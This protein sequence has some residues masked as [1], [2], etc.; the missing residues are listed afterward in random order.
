MKYVKFL[1][2]PL[3]YVALAFMTIGGCGGSSG[4]GD[5]GTGDTLSNIL[6]TLVKGADNPG[7]PIILFA[8]DKDTGEAVAG[9]GERDSSGNVLKITGMVYIPANGDPIFVT[10]NSD[11]LP[12]LISD[13]SG[14]SILID[15]YTDSSFDI[16]FFSDGVPT[17]GP[18]TVNVDPATLTQIQA[19]FNS[20]SLGSI[21]KTLKDQVDTTVAI[22]LTEDQKIFGKYLG[23]TVAAFGC[24][25]SPFGGPSMRF[26]FISYKLS[27]ERCS[28][29]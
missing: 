2:V 26:C 17:E 5:G 19:L 8:F 12:I 7:N 20:I 9:L 10:V 15:N 13:L 21:S 23:F 22:T 18:I 4:G 27:R 16:T 1:V 29:L 28:I 24:S 6:I 25:I 11:G 3:L 14:N